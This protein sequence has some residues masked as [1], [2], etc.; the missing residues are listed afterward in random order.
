MMRMRMLLVRYMVSQD[1][2]TRLFAVQLTDCL[3]LIPT[4]YP[5]PSSTFDLFR[6]K[7]FVTLSEKVERPALLKKK[8]ID[9]STNYRHSRRTGGSREQACLIRVVE[10]YSWGVPVH[11]Q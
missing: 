4:Q 7:W 8:N 6:T 2:Y 11:P 1:V 3:Y 10:L 5:P 9:I